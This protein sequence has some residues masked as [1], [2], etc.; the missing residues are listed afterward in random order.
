MNFEEFKKYMNCGTNVGLNLMKRRNFPSI[1]VAGKWLIDK[2][3]LIKWM[4]EQYK[5]PKVNNN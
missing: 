4:E 3:G 2:Q 1:K 5:K